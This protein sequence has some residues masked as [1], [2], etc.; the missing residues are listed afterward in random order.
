MRLLLY[1]TILSSPRYCTFF[2][3][4]KIEGKHELIKT[5]NIIMG[6]SMMTLMTTI[7]KS[8]NE[9]TVLISPNDK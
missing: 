5:G 4:D 3:S 2:Q 9:K 6:Y 7:N 8:I 1:E